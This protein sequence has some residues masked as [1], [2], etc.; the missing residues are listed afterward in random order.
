MLYDGV[1]G[2]PA[3][4]IRGLTKRFGPTTALAGVDLS[5]R[6]GES[7]ALIGRNGAGKSTL[8]SI[9]TGLS[10]ADEGDI[11]LYGEPVRPDSSASDIACVFQRTTLVPGLTAAENIFLGDRRHQRRGGFL[12]WRAV[13]RDAVAL[14]DE[15]G[16]ARIADR[17]VASLAPV[18]RKIVEICRAL[19]RGPSILLLDEPTAGLDEGAS[20]L[21]FDR[22]ASAR[23]RGVTIIYVSH[24][25]DEL[26]EVCDS[27]TVLRDGTDVH[28][29]PVN[30]VSVARIVELMIGPVE[31][32]QGVREVADRAIEREDVLVSLRAVSV[33]GAVQD[34]SLD[35]ARGECV[36]L[37]GLDGAG[38]I[39][40]AGVIAGTT[41]V[42]AGTAL[43]N[44]R[45]IDGGN[46]R[47]AIAAGIGSVPEDRHHDGFVPG[48]SVEENATM[49][50]LPRLSRR[51]GVVDRRRRRSIFTGLASEWA[52]KISG[53][54][55]AAEELSGGNQQKV[56]LARALASDPD[57]IVLINPTAG[58]DVAAKESIYR[59]IV[60][61][62]R[63]G[64]TVVVCS[65]DDADLAICD[66]TVA[67]VKNRIGRELASGWD[68]ATLVAAIH[69]GDDHQPADSE[70]APARVSTNHNGKDAS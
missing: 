13:R 41:R 50:I 51:F 54:D 52:I 7:R 8:I 20:R 45:P 38:H 43:L 24:H 9:L 34:V 64:C 10:T 23:A 47:A 57:L 28:T 19:S 42:S 27:I 48:L 53:P 32:S 2:A 1:D 70:L 61:L 3:I 39:Q 6:R 35:I 17:D 18:E 58:V 16:C 15:W 60:K 12:D 40:L 4:A 31:A 21:L 46:V 33:A 62:L 5:V 59:T 29:G 49:T 25:L 22:L 65:S 11:R 66:R 14:L 69:G 30:E 63:R 68:E 55:Q 44:G 56:V 67:V 36:G 26:Y 37:T